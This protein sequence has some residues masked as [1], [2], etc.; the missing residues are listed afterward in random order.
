MFDSKLI[1][2]DKDKKIYQELD[3]VY[4]MEE[5]AGEDF[6]NTNYVRFGIRGQMFNKDQKEIQMESLE[7]LNEFDLPYTVKTLLEK[8]EKWDEKEEEYQHIQEE[9]RE[10]KIRHFIVE[11]IKERAS[12]LNDE[13]NKFLELKRKND[14]QGHEEV[15]RGKEEDKKE[16]GL[17]YKWELAEDM[18]ITHEKLAVIVIGD[19]KEVTQEVVQFIGKVQNRMV[20]D[21][22]EL[23]DWNCENG[24]EVGV[25]IRK[26]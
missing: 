25:K 2:G 7:E 15:T 9:G 3:Q 13:H 18:K 4:R 21:M 24:F 22:S 20:L 12:E 8:K 16:G 6:R 10:D 5:F 26:L 14:M 11:V 17:V 19:S 1:L 23:I